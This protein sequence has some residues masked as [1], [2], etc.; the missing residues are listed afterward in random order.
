MRGMEGVGGGGEHEKW[1]RV[2]KAVEGTV[3]GAGGSEGY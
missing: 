1:W 3:V 2:L